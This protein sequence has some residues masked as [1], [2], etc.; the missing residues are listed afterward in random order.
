VSPLLAALLIAQATIYSWTDKDGVEHFTDDLGTVPK[1]V[2]VRTTEGGE[3]SR[4]EGEVKPVRPATVAVQPAVEPS[5]PSQSEQYWRQA[6]KSVRERIAELEDDVE[7]DRKL[8]EGTHGLPQTARFSCY[9]GA[10][11]MSGSTVVVNG[12]PLPG[13]G[14]VTNAPGTAY[15]APCFYNPEF[16]RVR[17][18]L[19][20]NRRA[21][22]RAKEELSDLERRASFEAVPLHWRR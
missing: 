10:W 19:D 22:T 17:D 4:I 8:I 16:E 1:G 15:G 11:W 21:L 13:G 14:V 5:V 12:Q 7:A 18:R 6:F 20:R 9:P 3:V 2:K